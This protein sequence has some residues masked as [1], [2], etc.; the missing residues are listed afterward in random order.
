V[1]RVG[2][3]VTIP[4]PVR[5]RSVDHVTPDGSEITL[6]RLN[7]TDQQLAALIQ[8]GRGWPWN[9]YELRLMKEAGKYP[10]QRLIARKRIT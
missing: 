1:P 6:R 5:S 10:L 4:H 7:L 3:K 8:R 9:G 2:D